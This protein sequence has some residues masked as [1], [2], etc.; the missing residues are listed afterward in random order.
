MRL[1]NLRAQFVKLFTSNRE[2]FSAQWAELQTQF[3]ETHQRIAELEKRYRPINKEQ[4]RLYAKFI[5]KHL[6]EDREAWLILYRQ[7]ADYYD[8]VNNLIAKEK[9]LI[10][11]MRKLLKILTNEKIFCYNKSTKMRK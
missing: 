6:P 1:L 9:H 10:E 4:R 7:T 2:S 3:T 8:E 11:E 5:E